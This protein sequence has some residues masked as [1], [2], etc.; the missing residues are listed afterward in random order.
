M[1]DLPLRIAAMSSRFKDQHL[2][3]DM[4]TRWPDKVGA[5]SSPRCSQRRSSLNIWQSAPCFG[6]HP[7]FSHRISLQLSPPAKLD[8]YAALFLPEVPV[9]D[10]MRNTHFA[11]LFESLPDPKPLS[12]ALASVRNNFERFPN[13]LLGST[14][15]LLALHP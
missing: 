12:D 10:A 13:A 9:E 4:A 11:K 5:L 15:P 3:A 8:H 7:W 1:E 6:F 2:V 14:Y